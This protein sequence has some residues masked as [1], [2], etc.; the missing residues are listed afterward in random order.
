MDLASH[1]PITVSSV[2]T[3][4]YHKILAGR[5]ADSCPS[6]DR[7]K[8]FQKGDRLLENVVLLRSVI[9]GVSNSSS[10]KPTAFAWLDV[11]KAFDSVSHESLIK[12]AGSLGV[13]GLLLRYIA[14]IYRGLTQ[15]GK[16]TD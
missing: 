4:L 6:S 3:L 12:A 16:K 9:D 7:Q 10:P 14:A 1:H 13:L 5:L 2:L 8:A 11:C 15:N